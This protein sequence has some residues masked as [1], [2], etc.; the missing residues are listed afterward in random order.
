MLSR[1]AMEAYRKMTP[2]ERFAQTLQAIRESFP[3]L[4]RGPLEV[5]DRRLELLRRE[6]DASNRALL[7]VLAA[8][9]RRK[10]GD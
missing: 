4:L 5:V 7:K 3:Y 6:N 8:A 9:E 1:E 2:D 10:E